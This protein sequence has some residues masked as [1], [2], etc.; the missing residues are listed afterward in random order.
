MFLPQLALDLGNFIPVEQQAGCFAAGKD[1]GGKFD[2][3][4]SATWTP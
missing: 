1:C 3:R 4:F 2:R